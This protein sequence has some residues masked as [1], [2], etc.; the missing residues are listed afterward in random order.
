MALQSSSVQ[1]LIFHQEEILADSCIALEFFLHPKSHIIKAKTGN[2][3]PSQVN[4]CI[5]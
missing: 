5:D 3:F 2:Y 1:W 4:R